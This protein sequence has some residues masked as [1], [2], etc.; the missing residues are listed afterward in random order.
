MCEMFAVLLIKGCLNFVYTFALIKISLTFLDNIVLPTGASKSQQ[1]TLAEGW[2]S[3]DLWDATGSDPTVCAACLPWPSLWCIVIG[4]LSKSASRS[5][6]LSIASFFLH[7]KCSSIS[8]SLENCLSVA[9]KWRTWEAIEKICDEEHP[10]EG[11]LMSS[12][13]CS[14]FQWIIDWL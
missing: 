8:R 2:P 3:G 6:T 11:T 5:D 12:G 4:R 10:K 13:K 7:G 1:N 9:S 14:L